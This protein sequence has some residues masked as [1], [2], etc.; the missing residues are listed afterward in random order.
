[1]LRGRIFVDTFDGALA[2]AGDILE[3]M[4]RG[5]ISRAHIEAELAD[6]VRGRVAG[7]TSSDEIIVFKSVGTAIEDVAAAQMIVGAG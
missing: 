1:M 5:V 6:L 4:S 7:R 3:P 2:E